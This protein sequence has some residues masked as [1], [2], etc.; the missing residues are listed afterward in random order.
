MPFHQATTPIVTFQAILPARM[1]RRGKGTIC[2][3]K[4]PFGIGII[5]D[6]RDCSP[7]LG[8]LTLAMNEFTSKLSLIFTNEFNR[9][10]YSADDLGKTKSSE[11]ARLTDSEI[12]TDRHEAMRLA[13]PAR[14]RLRQR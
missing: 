7:R 13:Y 9:G 3:T 12:R 6:I 2:G 5:T 10:R 14:D 1:R 4:C 11:L 8:E